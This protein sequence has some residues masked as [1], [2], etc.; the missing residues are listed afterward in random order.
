MS[1]QDVTKNLPCKTLEQFI[2]AIN[3]LKDR[4]TVKHLN[5]GGNSV[6]DENQR[7]NGLRFN[8]SWTEE[9]SI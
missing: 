9:E 4:K 2:E 3:S 1:K 6:Q 8:V 5:F 7:Q